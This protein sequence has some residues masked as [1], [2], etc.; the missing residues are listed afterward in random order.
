MDL[1]LSLVTAHARSALDIFESLGTAWRE[2]LSIW[3]D[4]CTLDDTF[5]WALFSHVLVQYVQVL[6]RIVAVAQSLWFPES[7]KT[8]PS[9]PIP[10]F[11][12][13]KNERCV[14]GYFVPVLGSDGGHCFQFRA[15]LYSIVAFLDRFRLDFPNSEPLPH[16]FQSRS[17]YIFRRSHVIRSK[18]TGEY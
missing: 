9:F 11:P 17:V 15:K 1:R 8:A 3:L 7:R 18:L 16:G 6:N 14:T 5:N 2:S 12:S 13:D 10:S 4:A